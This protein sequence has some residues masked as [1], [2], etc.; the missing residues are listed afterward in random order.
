M[1]YG[2]I[3]PPALLAVPPLACLNLHASLLPRWRGAAPIQAAIAAGDRET[4]ITVMDMDAGLDTGDILLRRSIDILP[5]DNVPA[6]R[7]GLPGSPRTLCLRR[8]DCSKAESPRAR[9]RKASGPLTL[10]D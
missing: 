8:C 10:Q 2:Q 7:T 1:A 3:L 5:D 9:P 6:Y 4:G